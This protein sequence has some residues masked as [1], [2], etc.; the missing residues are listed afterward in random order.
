M[1]LF[2]KKGLKIEMENELVIRLNEN[3]LR[4]GLNEAREIRD[5]LA[6]AIRK[7]DEEPP[8]EFPQEKKEDFKLFGENEKP[9][10]Y[11]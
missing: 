9:E 2:D 10:L 5:K 8:G 7:K 3:E 6:M 1:I 4:L 11:Y